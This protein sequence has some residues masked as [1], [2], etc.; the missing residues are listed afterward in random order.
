MCVGRK[1]SDPLLWRL[2]SFLGEKLHAWQLKCLNQYLA[3][4]AR[5]RESGNKKY[6]LIAS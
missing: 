6:K 5:G 4:R 1:M 2:V 3:D